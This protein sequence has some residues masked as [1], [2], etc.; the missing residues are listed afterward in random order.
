MST[1][2]QPMCTAC[3]GGWFGQ[4]TTNKDDAITDADTHNFLRPGHCAQAI[5]KSPFCNPQTK[6]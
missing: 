3:E 2:W 5:Q 1:W 6:N 4:Y